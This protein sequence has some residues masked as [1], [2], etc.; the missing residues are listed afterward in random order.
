MESKYESIW[1][2]TTKAVTYPSLE[3]DLKVDCVII[4]GGIA[5]LMAAYFLQNEG[6]KVAI[7]EANTLVSGTSAYTTAKVTSMHG[8]KYASLKKNFG[9][10]K[11]KLYAD[12]NE[13]AIDE[14]EKIIQN[15]STMTH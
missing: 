1:I 2:H 3:K 13:W 10:E 5:G 6:K 7:L 4:G 14:L 11:T 8:A 12:S 15:T 9:A